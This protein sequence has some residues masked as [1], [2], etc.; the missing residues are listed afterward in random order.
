MTVTISI[1]ENFVAG[2]F[3]LLEEELLSRDGIRKFWTFEASIR[4]AE[5]AVDRIEFFLEA[6]DGFREQLSVQLDKRAAAAFVERDDGGG[7][8][9]FRLLFD[10]LRLLFIGVTHEGQNRFEAADGF[11]FDFAVFRWPIRAA[12]DRPAI[13]QNEHRQGP[14]GALLGHG[15][16]GHVNLIDVRTPL[17]VHFDTHERVVE[18]LGDRF[19]AK[20][21]AFHDVTPVTRA[22]A[23]RQ[24]NQ[25]AL[26]LGFFERFRAPRIP[27]GGV[28]RVHEQIGACLL[29]EAIGEFRAFRPGDWEA[30]AQMRPAKHRNEKSAATTTPKS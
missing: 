6:V 10:F 1:V 5:A 8:D 22:V 26:F 25:L 15:Q 3:A 24:K 12:R 11:V 18:N 21:F 14:T 23:D 30:A 20:G 16:R 29:G 4:I 27:V 2:A 28:V 17:A 7:C 9:F 19:V 13:R